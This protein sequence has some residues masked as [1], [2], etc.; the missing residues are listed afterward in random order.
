[1]LGGL[2]KINQSDSVSYLQ[3]LDGFARGL[4][5]SLAN[6]T[7]PIKA[8][9]TGG[10]VAAGGTFNATV[11]NANLLQVG[12]GVT[13]KDSSGNLV[14]G[15]ISAIAGTVVTITSATAA[16]VA[17]ATSLQVS[18]PIALFST[19][20]TPAGQPPYY[21]GGITLNQGL[22]TSSAL[23]ATLRMGS[24]ITGSVQ[25]TDA[26]GAS[27][28]ADQLA[29]GTVNFNHLAGSQTPVIGQYS[30]FLDAANAM[31]VAAGQNAT[32]AVNNITTLTTYNNQISQSIGNQSGVNIDVEMSNLVVLQNL[33]SSNARV[34]SVSQSM[35]DALMSIAR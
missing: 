12:Q 22:I 18:T 25:P 1:M 30:T 10:A 9:V 13:Y 34:M 24:F 15:S 23:N 2:Q 21:S 5:S 28:A 16:T 4:Q 6:L 29:R 20:T 17:A 3:Q 19:P 33:Y 8:T 31:A 27:G 26:L 7:S 14:N 11:T 32:N 35:L